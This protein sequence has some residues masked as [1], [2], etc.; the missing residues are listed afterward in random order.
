MSVRIQL[1]N[2]HN[3]YTNLDFVT[4]RIILNL[5]S[6][7]DV[8]AIVV[9]LEGECRTALLRPAGGIQNRRDQRQGSVSE[10]HK[11]LYRVVQVFPNPELNS[12][13]ASQ[14]YFLRAGQHQYPFRIKMPFNTG[15]WDPRSQQMVTGSGFGRFGLQGLQQLQYRHV[16]Q[17]LPPSL[18]GFPGEAEIR[19]YVKVTVQRPGLFKENRRTE[20]GFK[21][22][23]IEPPRKPPT[24]EEMFARRSFQ[25]QAGLAQ[26]SKKSSMFKKTAKPMSDIAPQ[27]EIDAR[28]PK[29][30][31]LTCNEPIPLR[32]VLRK[33]NDSPEHVFLTSLQVTL[34]G[35]TSVRAMDVVRNEIGTWVVISLNGLAI[36]IGN[37]SDCVRTETKVNNSLWERIPLPNTVAPTFHA[38]NISRKYMLELKVGLAYGTPGNI[39]VNTI[40]LWFYPLIY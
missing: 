32:L 38:C 33:L 17:T 7:E 16:K 19:Y 8:A 6:D 10:N 4:G 22:L 31:I 23:P 27:G 13:M 25:F 12:Q 1:D 36:P 24:D 29:P 34:V 11:I 40:Q 37:P 39:Q 2:P 20:V 28:I 14:T 30:P 26:Y 21:F 3:F 9:K 5:N 18:T 15:C 35:T